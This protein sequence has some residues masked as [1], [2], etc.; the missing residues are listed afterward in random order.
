MV[1]A[2]D[3]CDEPYN[4]MEALKEISDSAPGYLEVLVSSRHIIRV[5]DVF[6]DFLQVDVNASAS[7]ADMK[8]YIQVE[9]TEREKY[10]R[11]LGGNDPK[12]EQRLVDVLNKQS[13]GMYV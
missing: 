12:T 6:P 9:V 7:K 13:N 2:L 11:L 4:L 10:R 5:N 1:D 3:E 8:E